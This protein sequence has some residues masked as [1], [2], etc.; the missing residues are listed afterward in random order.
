MMMKHR[1]QVKQVNDPQPQNENTTQSGSQ[2]AE[3]GNV[4]PHCITIAR[5]LIQQRE[6]LC[7]VQSTSATL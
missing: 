7:L 3:L 4:T 2:Q 1:S 6:Q 5:P